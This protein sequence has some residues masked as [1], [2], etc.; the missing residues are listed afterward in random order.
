MSTEE[1]ESCIISGMVTFS[2]NCIFKTLRMLKLKIPCEMMG[3][4]CRKA[5]MILSSV[6]SATTIT[7]ILIIE[8]NENCD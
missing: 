3:F 8:V 7:A 5:R 4:M 6:R 1:L 2:Y